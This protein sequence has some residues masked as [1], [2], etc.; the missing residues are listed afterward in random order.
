M[1][2]ILFLS[3]LI[4]PL[5]GF[6]QQPGWLWANGFGGFNGPDK[7][8][9][10]MLDSNGNI[11]VAGTFESQS[12][13]CGTANL[14]NSGQVDILVV[15]YSSQG[16]ILWAKSFGS[17]SAE[18]ITGICIDQND[19]IYITGYFNS[20][21]L[22]FGTTQLLSAGDKDIFVAK[23]NPTGEPI[24][25][26]SF[27]GNG[28]DYGRGIA[29]DNAGSIYITGDFTSNSISFDTITINRSTGMSDIFIVKLSTDGNIQWAKQSELDHITSRSTAA[30]IIIDNNNTLILAGSFED[31][32]QG[33]A[34]GN[35]LRFGSGT[36]TNKNYDNYNGIN[37]Y[38][39]TAMVAK[40]DLNGDFLT[41]YSDSLKSESVSLAAD[42]NNNIYAS[43]FYEG[44]IMISLPYGA[45]SIVKLNANLDFQWRN[46]HEG[47]YT[48][49][50]DLKAFNNKIY[51]T[52]YFSSQQM[53]FQT[54]TLRIENNGGHHY[55]DLFLLKFDTDG[56]YEKVEQ[57]GGSISDRAASVLPISDAELYLIGNYESDSLYLG[58]KMLRNESDTG[59]FHVHVMPNWFWRHSNVF[60][61]RY[62]ENYNGMGENGSDISFK[63]YPNP[64]HGSFSV[65][66]EGITEISVFSIDGKKVQTINYSKQDNP[67]NTIHINIRNQVAGIYLVKVVSK[68]GTAVREIIKQ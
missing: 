25:A 22:S 6:S 53:V 9:D 4:L 13:T 49:C 20:Q 45:F 39:P 46:D 50:T 43:F 21:T 44:G 66:G 48:S 51:A 11:I 16:N 40:F 31:S 24:W 37:Y 35:Y 61:A 59:S 42:Q 52:G 27:G 56:N 28:T 15:K 63:I 64:N 65:M 32:A 47:G 7:A 62:T 2:N 26:K 14:T 30:D 41:G 5:T 18:Y 33:A 68:D 54:D 57:F 60:V 8:V 23:L 36:I 55:Y 67:T 10:A 38:Y 12:L 58:D 17:Q 1:K 34:G 29:S 3:L 19:N